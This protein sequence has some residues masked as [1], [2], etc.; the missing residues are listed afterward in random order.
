MAWK[1]AHEGD[2]ITFIRYKREAFRASEF[3]PRILADQGLKV[4]MKVRGPIP[5]MIH[6][7]IRFIERSPCT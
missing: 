2:V 6:S 1:N 5:S 3:A 7:K 4:A